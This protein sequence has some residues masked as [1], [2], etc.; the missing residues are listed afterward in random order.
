MSLKRWP[1]RGV[2]NHLVYKNIYCAMC[3]GIN[4]YNR[5]NFSHQNW[6]G[7][8]KKR[9][10]ISPVVEW[11][12]AK[13]ECAESAIDSYLTNEPTHKKLIDLIKSKQ[14]KCILASLDVENLF[15]NVPI[16]KI[17]K[18]VRINV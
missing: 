17:I 13:I 6:I 7:S 10:G 9:N 12:P 16:H 15:I 4:P 11:Y 14:P 2:T 5:V 18:I 8:D 3:N 1:V